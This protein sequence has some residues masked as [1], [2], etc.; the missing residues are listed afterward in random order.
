MGQYRSLLPVFSMLGPFLCEEDELGSLFFTE[1]DISHYR[2]EGA[3]LALIVK[4]RRMKFTFAL[5]VLVTFRCFRYITQVP[6]TGNSIQR[7][8]Y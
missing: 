8:P 3:A 7:I 1:Y 4:S 5:V 6:P 2:F